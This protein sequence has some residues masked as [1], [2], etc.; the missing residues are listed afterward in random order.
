VP[1]LKTNKAAK[2]RFKV[3]ATGKVLFKP[4][5]KKHLMSGKAA[6]RR[7]KMRRWRHFDGTHD[8]KDILLITGNK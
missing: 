7:R 6:K 2:K 1:K 4:A 5:G 3:T 8:A